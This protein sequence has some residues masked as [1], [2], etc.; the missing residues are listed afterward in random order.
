M[1]YHHR[2]RHRPG[3]KGGGLG[4]LIRRGVQFQDVPLTY[5]KDGILEAQAIRIFDKNKNPI[6]ILNIYKCPS[7]KLSLAEIKHYIQQLGN[8]FIITGDFNAHSP[9]LH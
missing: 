7:L 2:W 3:P 1:Y 8:K 5:Y 9:I 6:T 4:I